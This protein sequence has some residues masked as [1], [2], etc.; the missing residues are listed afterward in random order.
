MLSFQPG[1]SCPRALNSTLTSSLTVRFLPP[2]DLF[3][4]FS[5][6]NSAKVIAEDGFMFVEINCLL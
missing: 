3:V 4:L 1:F 6:F 5:H 2:V